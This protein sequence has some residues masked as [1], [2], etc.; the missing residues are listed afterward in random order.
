MAGENQEGLRPVGCK[1]SSLAALAPYL[2]T[3]EL[4]VVTDDDTTRDVVS[5]RVANRAPT[6]EADLIPVQLNL[7]KR[8]TTTTNIDNTGYH[9]FCNT[10]SAGYTVTLPTGTQNATYRITN[11]GS[12]GN[13]L[14]I[15]PSGSEHLL[16]A[17]SNQTRADGE[18]FILSYDTTDGWY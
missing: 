7:I 12:S 15:A 11:T 14:T 18:Y 5:L 6:T 10:D 4:V 8:V 13:T 9:W 17:N 2:Y 1:E 3:G 16:G